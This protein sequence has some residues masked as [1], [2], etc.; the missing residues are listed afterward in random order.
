[1]VCVVRNLFVPLLFT[2]LVAC[3]QPAMKTSSPQQA[4]HEADV[5]TD[6]AMSPAISSRLREIAAAGRLASLRWPDFSDYRAHFQQAYEST[7]F[8]LLWLDHGRPSKQAL[9]LIQAWKD[10]R[11]KGLQPEEYDATRWD[12]RVAQLKSDPASAADFDAAFTVCAMRYISDLHIGRVDP[13][14]FKF[15]IDIGEKKYDLPHFL[16]TKLAHADNMQ[17]V[18]DSVEPHYLGYRN[19]ETALQHYEAL[20]ARGDGDPVPDVAQTV[21]AGDAYAGTKALAA[22]LE[23]LGD[24]AA[25]AE[26][27]AAAGIYDAPLSAAVERFQSRHGLAV[28]GRLGK[29]TIRQLNVP[30][31]V[32]V[33]QLEDALERWRWLPPAFPQP[34]IVVN[35]PEFV[36]RVF[37]AQEQV[38]I[39]MN[40]VVGRAIG[41]ETPIFADQMRYIVFRPYWNIPPSIVRK[42][43]LPG[44][45]RD[46]GYLPHKRMEITD[47]N[48]KV[49]A[50]GAVSAA[51]TDQLRRGAVMIR[52]RPGADNSL[53]LIKFI[54]PNSS[55]IYLHSTPAP[56][57]FSQSRRDFSHGCI[58]VERP[59]ELAGYLLADQGWTE[60]KA[61]AA[62]Q[63]GQDN[64]QVNLSHL[65]PVLLLYV[66]AVVEQDGSVQFFD[67]IYGHDKALNTVLA[68]GP[69]YPGQ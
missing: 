35:V 12:E 4:V 46:P 11:A 39:R 15:G 50:A 55:N 3:S 2:A 38:K 1:M 17:A 25:G 20:A 28:D 19:T 45:A 42:E 13:K 6:P 60:Q 59:A 66:T 40:V 26:T 30:L 44:L 33:M 58:R 24:L 34:P 16:T 48:G 29:G 23:L 31:A 32:R 65:V 18:L 5:A 47:R 53:G 21:G 14:H 7:N 51:L 9:V 57:L 64:R 56:Q 63:S 37:D 27:N 41:T 8:T 67:D 43:V 36:L 49:L 52:Q 68:K 61:D 10:S 69:P 54:F 22:R 62:M